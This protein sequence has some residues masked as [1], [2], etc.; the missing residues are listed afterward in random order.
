MRKGCSLLRSGSGAN[1]FSRPQ[2]CQINNTT[3]VITTAPAVPAPVKINTTT[4]CAYTIKGKG[5]YCGNDRYAY[6]KTNGQ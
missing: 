1:I 2:N 6:N 3:V 5:K 4:S